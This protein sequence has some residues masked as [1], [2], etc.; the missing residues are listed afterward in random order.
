MLHLQHLEKDSLLT[1]EEIL[2]RKIGR[3]KTLYKP[4]PKLLETLRTK[5]D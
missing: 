5:S 2:Q 4:T 1:K 3:P